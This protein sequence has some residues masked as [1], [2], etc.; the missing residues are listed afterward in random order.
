MS[1]NCSYLLYRHEIENKDGSISINAD[2]DVA[3][4]CYLCSSIVKLIFKDPTKNEALSMRFICRYLHRHIR[5]YDTPEQVLNEIHKENEEKHITD[6]EHGILAGECKRF[7]H[8]L[9]LRRQRDV[10]DGISDPDGDEGCNIDNYHRSYEDDAEYDFECVDGQQEDIEMEGADSGKE[11][12]SQVVTQKK[13][14]VLNE[15]LRF[16]KPLTRLLF[17]SLFNVISNTLA[18]K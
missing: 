12:M 7:N 11:T 14:K 9:K 15:L 6:D 17:T 16:L 1:H 18:N 4:M 8:Y 3:K 5:S 10:T 13:V 2:F